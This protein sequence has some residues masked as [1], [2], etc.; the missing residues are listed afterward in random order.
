MSLRLMEMVDGEFSVEILLLWRLVDW[1]GVK[2]RRICRYPLLRLQRMI[3]RENLEQLLDEPYVSR[4]AKV[5]RG[6]WD[7]P[8]SFVMGC[9]RR[10]IIVKGDE[11]ATS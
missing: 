4:T 9:M 10:N 6:L 5:V 2:L 7:A 1:N 3:T 8:A 11:N